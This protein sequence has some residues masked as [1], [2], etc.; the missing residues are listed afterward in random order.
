MVANAALAKKTTGKSSS[1]AMPEMK[2]FDPPV[3]TK[4]DKYPVL[5][6]LH[7]WG[8]NH[9]TWTGYTNVELFAEERNIAVVMLSAENKSYINMNDGDRFYDFIQNELPDFV[10][11]NFP[12]ST[13]PQNTYIAGLS[14]GGFGTYVHGLSNPEK[15]RA[16]GAFS[17]A[18]SLNPI[19]MLTGEEKATDPQ[20]DPRS[21]AKKIHGEGRKFPKI[22]IGCGEKDFLFK[23]NETF[24]NELHDMGADVTW[25][26]VPGYGH[27]WRFWNEIVEKF[28][29]WLPRTDAYAR[30]GRRQI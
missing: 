24:K 30:K 7:G 19:M 9:A 22:F 26:P 28:L 11:G 21:I 12:V 23:D 8:N 13:D 25:V 15:Y 3:H 4:Q 17:A 14:M 10:C 18:V 27:E 2:N 29:D 16:I 20:Y 6:L 5:Y 1:A